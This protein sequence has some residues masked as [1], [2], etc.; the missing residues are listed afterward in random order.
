MGSGN[1]NLVTGNICIGADHTDTIIDGGTRTIMYGNKESAS[2]DFILSS[3]GQTVLTIDSNG[4]L[5]IKGD[6]NT[7]QSL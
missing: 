5:K 3:G 1:D 7:N 6:I 4:L 2:G